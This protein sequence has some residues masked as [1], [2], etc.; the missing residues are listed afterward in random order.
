M[1]EGVDFLSADKFESF[2][3]GNSITFGVR[4]Q[5]CPKYQK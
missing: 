2:L 4:I 3:Q 5:A 1:E